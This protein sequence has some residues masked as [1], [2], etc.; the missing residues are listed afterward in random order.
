MAVAFDAKSTSSVFVGPGVTSFTDGSLTVGN[1]ANRVLV[2]NVNFGWSTF[3]QP[4]NISVV[5]DAAGVN[6]PLSLI[7]QSF[8]NAANSLTQLWGLIA[9]VSGN[10]ILT[11]S[12]TNQTD[13]AKAAGASF[14]GANQTGGTTTFNFTN[15]NKGNSSTPSVQIST[16]VNDAVI[17]G[18]VA[19]GGGSY[20]ATNDNEIFS[21]PSALIDACANYELN[22]A[23]PITMNVSCSGIADWA[24]VGTNISA[25]PPP[26]PG[27]VAGHHEIL[28]AAFNGHSGP[29]GG[30]VSVPGLVVG[31]KLIWLQSDQYLGGTVQMNSADYFEVIISANDQIRQIVTVDLSAWTFKAIFIRGI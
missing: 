16:T 4:T 17:G 26:P 10:K 7:V 12:W 13:E 3:S 25:A 24:Y 23:S 20:G 29:G 9:P 27:T 31:D 15:T 21:D 6:Q 19:Q 11:C 30:L 5:W 14:T 28:G 2:Y 1:A 8:N 22:G 18:S